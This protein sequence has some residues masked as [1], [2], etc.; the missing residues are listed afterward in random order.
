MK[1]ALNATSLNDRPSG[2]RHRFVGIYGPLFK[3]LKDV[4][5]IIYEPKDCSVV[6][7][8]PDQPN[9]SNR[10]TPIPSFGRTGKF[11]AGINYWPR[12]LS[13]E[14]FDIFEAM[15]LPL[16]RPPAGK[17]ILTIHDIRGLNKQ[18]NFTNRALFA[19]VLKDALKRADH[20]VTVSHTMRSE[21][22][23]FHA[24]AS[25][26]VIYNGIDKAAMAN[27]A[28]GRIDKFRTRYGLAQEYILAVGH[29][30]P[31]KN[32]PRLIEAM[33][34]LKQR[35][36]DCPLVIIGN[37]SGEASALKRLI[38]GLGLD[39]QVTLLTGLS[40]DDVRCAYLNCKLFVFPSFYEGFGIPILEAMAARK[41]MVLSDVAIFREI[42]QNRSIYFNQYCV[43][44]MADAIEIG[45]CSEE[46]VANMVE[47]GDQRLEDFKFTRQAEKL[48]QLYKAQSSQ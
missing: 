23:K 21:I 20:I 41:P 43:E 22:L 16:T 17:T 34:L 32:Y 2:A 48:A 24:A 12:A 39:Q 7:W 6:D 45:I 4:E 27:V 44:S 25:V 37:D 10:K 46:A 38:V 3:H 28:K 42:T 35:G 33:S 26:S 14:K 15:H 5:F 31:R 30:E 1:V 8:F 47:Y 13:K 11:L 29:F 9:I 40:D 36:T 19:A 18:N